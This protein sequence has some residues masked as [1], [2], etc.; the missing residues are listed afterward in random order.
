MTHYYLKCQGI[1]ANLLNNGD[2]CVLICESY[3]IRRFSGLSAFFEQY[4]FSMKIEK[5]VF[6]IEEIVFC[7]TQP[8]L[9]SGSYRMVRQLRP[10]LEK[11]VTMNIQRLT[12]S[13]YDQW[14][15]AVAL[16]GLAL[17]SGIPVYQSFY[18]FMGRG[19]GTAK[20]NPFIGGLI[21]SGFYRLS[22]GMR[23][24]DLEVSMET[25]MSFWT[26]FGVTPDQ[27]IWME[28]YFDALDHSFNVTAPV[29]RLTIQQTFKFLQN[30]VKYI[31]YKW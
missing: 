8:V 9:I 5:A 18:K 2:D 24:V 4:G 1:R 23:P 12:R 26:A 19:T 20:C 28:Q 21:S 27:Q 13:L 6:K 7:Q 25:R 16:G 14:R 30:S 10:G 22:R 17:C 31:L 11:D 3:N 15:N 29:E